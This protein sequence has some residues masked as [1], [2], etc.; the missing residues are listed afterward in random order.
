MSSL[1]FVWVASFALLAGLGWIFSRLVATRKVFDVDLEWWQSFRPDR[2]APVLRLLSPRDME[3]AA[4]L[5]G[6]S[7][8]LVNEFKRNRLNLMRAYITEMTADFDRLQAMGQLMVTAGAAG[9]ELREAL[10]RERVRFTAGLLRI[11]FQMAGFRLGLAGV[12]ASVLVGSLD[13]LS[14]ALRAQQGYAA[15]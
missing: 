15:A 7:R 12:D 14:A 10:F 1:T 3:Y 8:R 13:E 11:R 6:G 2:Y 4:V 9:R 5:E